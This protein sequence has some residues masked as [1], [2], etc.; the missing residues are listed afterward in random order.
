ML[1]LHFKPQSLTKHDHRAARAAVL[2][3]LEKKPEGSNYRIEVP[4]EWRFLVSDSKEIVISKYS[5]EILEEKAR[6]FLEES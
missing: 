4:E 1:D 3:K 2:C 6:E 5:F